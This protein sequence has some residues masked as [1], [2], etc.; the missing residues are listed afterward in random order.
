M[1]RV[2]IVGYGTIGKRVADAVAKQ[3]DMVLVGVVKTKPDY[4]A[5]TAIEKGYKLYVPMSELEKFE[6][7]GIEVVGT[8]EDLVKSVD[9]VVDATPG[10]IGAKNRAEIYD[11]YGVRT[12]FQGGEK[13]NV[14]EVSFN[15]L[16][17]YSQAVGKRYIRVVSCNTTAILRII[18]ALRLWG[19]EIEKVRVFVA[20]R[21]ADPR[22]YSRG[23]INDF[24]LDPAAIP[25][26][27]AADVK[28]VLPDID[29][30]T[31]AIAT[32]VTIAH[33]HFFYAVLREEIS[34][35]RVLEALH[36]TPRIR[37]F[38]A[39]RGFRSVAQVLEWA[40][41]VGRPRSDVPENIVFADT[42][43][44]R[45]RELFLVMAVHQ[46]SIV[47]PENIDAIRAA[48]GIRDMWSSIRVTDESLGLVMEGKKYG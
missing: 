18:A 10:G 13:A 19:I 26:H 3:R 42:V 15:A 44:A 38:E 6:K 30:V 48:M 28:S 46:E 41:D 9:I 45:G 24:V 37:L 12:V 43:T 2:G 40:R 27:H 35:D 16:A 34:R 8:V 5:L 31:A 25:S 32:P 23:P 14:A 20:R 1:I 21:G 11:K 33:V 29:I 7:V 22:E 17:N 4:G 39:A 47:V 36:R